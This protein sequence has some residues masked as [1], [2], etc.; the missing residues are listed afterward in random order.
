MVIN[1]TIN[2]CI[3]YLL[4]IISI[5]TVVNAEK[6]KSTHSE[7]NFSVYVPESDETK[8]LNLKKHQTGSVKVYLSTLGEQVDKYMVSI[9][10][11]GEDKV[12]A[13]GL[14]DV[15]GEISFRKLSPGKYTVYLNKKVNVEENEL[16]T[17]KIGDFY[18]KATP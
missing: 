4:T 2:K 1:S 16:T 14:T 9:I 7:K 17:V 8:E 11:L 5:E 15:H 18:L 13:S 6:P 3:I 10:R 12:V